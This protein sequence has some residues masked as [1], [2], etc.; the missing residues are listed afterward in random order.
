MKKILLNS[1]D[2]LKSA[3]RFFGDK[4]KHDIECILSSQTYPCILIGHYSD[5]IEFGDGYSFTTIIKDDFNKKS[6]Q[7]YY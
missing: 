4:Y 2:D 7:V 5:D 6:G 3:I 1:K